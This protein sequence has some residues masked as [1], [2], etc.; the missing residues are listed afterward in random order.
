MNRLILVR[1]YTSGHDLKV[2]K[3]ANPILI[4]IE[5]ESESKQEDR[6]KKKIKTRIGKVLL[7]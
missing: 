7:F 4:E 2:G 5:R 1:E 3:I 6:R